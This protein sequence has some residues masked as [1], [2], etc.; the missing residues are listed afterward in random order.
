MA[1]LIKSISSTD[2]QHILS[3]Y[4]ELLDI[5]S[6]FDRV[7]RQN[8]I[9]SDLSGIHSLYHKHLFHFFKLLQA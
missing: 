7:L 9:S 3:S 5:Q 2:K 4:K 8:F 6:N 1:I